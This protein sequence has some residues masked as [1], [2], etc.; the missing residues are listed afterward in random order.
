MPPLGQTEPVETN[1]SDN[2]D[3]L[4]RERA[5]L[6]D[7][8]NQFASANDRTTTVEDADDDLL[9]GGDDFQQSANQGQDM[10]GFESSFPAI[11]S[12][13]E[14]RIFSFTFRSESNSPILLVQWERDRGLF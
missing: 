14:V 4:A 3:F 1:G 12:Q 7:D 2:D 13:N 5:A 9:G 6:G 10:S 11:E 8:A